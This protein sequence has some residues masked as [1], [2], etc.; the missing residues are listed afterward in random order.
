M[1][2]TAP[3][4]SPP[5]SVPD[6]VRLPAGPLA[7]GVPGWRGADAAAWAAAGPGRWARPLWSVLALLVTVVVAIV[8]EPVPVCGDATPCGPDWYGLVQTALAIG[9]LHWNA[10]L[11]ELTLVAAPTVAVLVVAGYF[12]EPGVASG[13]ALGE[14]SVVSV[15]ANAAVVAALAL[16]W[17]AAC[18]RLAARRRQRLLFART[19]GATTFPS[20]AVTAGLPRRSA[21]PLAAGLLL[22]A[23]AVAATLLGLRGVHADEDRAARATRTEAEVTHRTDMSLTLRTEDGRR[24]VVDAVYPEDQRLGATVTVLEDGRWRRLVAEPYDAVGWQLLALVTGL[25]GVSL[26]G[27]GL[28]ALR[29]SLALRRGDL[30]ALR[31]F[32]AV[33]GEGTATLHATDDTALRMPLTVFT[34]DLF[35][36]YGEDEEE[37][38]EE[39]AEE[40]ELGEGNEPGEG[41]GED[42]FTLVS[43][44]ETVMFGVPYEGAPVVFLVPA[45]DRELAEVVAPAVVQPLWSGSRVSGSGCSATG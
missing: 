20:A 17:A 23:L 15:A 44:R 10:R 26:T 1:S 4:T 21:Y 13:G 2:P 38:P 11:P 5:S 29:R 45:P 7:D 34:W 35:F 14:V 25:P 18:A 43:L 37:A 9:L 6:P 8:V 3:P 32:Q 19:S 24:I 42:E 12:T 16:G 36:P 27:T 22:C 30:P 40:D 39:D 28:R 31:V 33:D 41:D